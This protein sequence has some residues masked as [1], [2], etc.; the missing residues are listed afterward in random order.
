[1]ASQKAGKGSP[2]LKRAAKASTKAKYKNQFTRTYRN[3]LR[4]ILQS[5]GA[6]AAAAYR[7]TWGATP[8]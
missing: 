5:N 2:K 1:M 3:K 6:E 7:A 4:R 8:R